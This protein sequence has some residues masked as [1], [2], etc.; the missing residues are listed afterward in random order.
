VSLFRGEEVAHEARVRAVLGV[1]VLRASAARPISFLEGEDPGMA[2]G[3]VSCWHCRG[4]APAGDHCPACGR[5][6]P[7]AE[8]GDHFRR[9]GL[10]RRLSLD[11]KALEARFHELSRRF[12]PDYYQLRSEQEQAISLE[13]SAAVNTAYRTLRDPIARAEYL[14]GL[15]GMPIETGQGAPPAELF[16]EIME[17][18]ELL[19]EYRE[20]RAQGD[21]A[22]ADLEARLSADRTHLEARRAEVEAKLFERFPRW[23]AE[24]ERGGEAGRRLLEEIR[25]LLATRAYLRTILRDLNGV[26]ERAG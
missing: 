9:L 21:G 3:S 25:A 12:H 6:Q 11:G 10:P 14:L 23:D 24:A 13:N 15:E 17:L 2:N 4:S 16:E 18:Q 5:L 7:F 22:G 19:Q 20:A 8:G 1:S 26:L